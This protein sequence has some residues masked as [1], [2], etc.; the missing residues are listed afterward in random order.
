MEA[1]THS[2]FRIG[3]I[4]FKNKQ[5]RDEPQNARTHTSIHGGE[6]KESNWLNQKGERERETEAEESGK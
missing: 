3:G 5:K 6:K 2:E 1:V 4:V